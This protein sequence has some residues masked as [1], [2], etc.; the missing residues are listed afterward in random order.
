MNNKQS[1]IINKPVIIVIVIVLLISGFSILLNRPSKQFV[2]V[3][4]GSQLSTIITKSSGGYAYENTTNEFS[5]YFK[6]KVTDRNSISFIN[7]LGSISFYT[8]KNQKFG[9]LNSDSPPASAGSTITYP[10]IFNQ[11]DVR[12][13]ISTTTL[14]EEFIVKD[15][16][17][18]NQVTDIK[19]YA[20]TDL[21]YQKNSDG[22]IVFTK[23]GKIVFILPA[24]VL[25]EL[26]NKENRSTGIKYEIEKSGGQLNITKIITP[27]GLTWINDPKRQY[28]IVID[29]VIDNAD[30]ASSWVSSDATNTVVSQ[31]TTVKQEGTGSVKVQTTADVNTTVD[32]ME[33]SSDAAA[34]TAYVSSRTSNL[35]TGGS[36][37]YSGGNTIHT[38]T[39]S[40][41]FTPAYAMNVAVLVVGGGGGGGASGGGGGGGIQ[42]NAS[43]AISAGS[44]SVTVGGGGAVHTSGGSSVFSSLTALGGGYGGNS[45]AGEAGGNGAC[46]GGGGS[47]GG[48]AGSSSQG[49]GAGYGGYAA[50]GGGGG[51]GS[52]GDNFGGG[53]SENWGGAGG[54]GVAYSTS[55]SSIYYG[56]GGSGGGSAT[57]GSNPAKTGGTNAGVNGA[58]NTGAAGG[59]GGAGGSGIVIISYTTVSNILQSY[60][61]STIKT[62]GSYSLKGVAYATNSLNQTLT[63]TI[64]SPVNLSN[65]NS[66][67]F[68]I[69]STRTGANIKIGLHDSG[70]VTTEIT[71]NITSA[72]TFQSVNIDLSG[73][74]NVNKD[75]I[76][77]I[78]ITITNAG[79]DN[80]FYLDNF[81]KLTQPSLNDTVTLTKSATD[82]SAHTNIYFWVRST[83]AGQTFRF[84]FGEASSSEQTYNVTINTANTWEQ[85]TWNISG[86]SA[87]SRDAVTKF[88]FQITNSTSAQ[89]INFD[90]LNTNNIPPNVPIIDSP[91]NNQSVDLSQPVKLV[92]HA[93]DNDLDFLRYQIKICTDLAMTLNCNTYDQTSS[94]TGWSGQN[95]QSNTAYT[96]GSS[97][98][99][100]LQSALN[101][102]S[103]YFW[104]SKAIDSTPGSNTWGAFQSTASKFTTSA[105]PIMSQNCLLQKSPQNNSIT[106]NWS[107]I[108]TDENGYTIEKKI[109]SGA[110]SNL[111]NL[112]A[113]TVTYVDN[114][115]SSGH[116]YQY[117]VTSYYTGPI[118][119]DWC[120]TPALD[121]ET[122]DVHIEGV[123]M[124]G[125]QIY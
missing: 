79:A 1:T 43:Y 17:T 94:Q 93:T 124:E 64:G 33:Y 18:A 81:L 60:T 54:G 26:G 29:L 34:Q 23:K 101:P 99:Y 39:S 95:T 59:A 50:G 108:A 70:G 25:Y 71:P 97:A 45:A 117:R 68:D 82:L 3:Q 102:S 86:I 125:I 31:D 5:T 55:G 28:P 83:L 42:Y 98:T 105:P 88:A 107:D 51:M 63:R 76:D 115:V 48:G 72:N 11:M 8:P 89:T 77:Q 75:A 20:N 116:I 118:Y 90:L 106:I 38:F 9:Q 41:T 35:G 67:S 62:Q 30:T 7:S 73:V 57:G 91:S 53:D 58:T 46:G 13:T 14:L 66:A 6:E 4:D 111:I 84:Q 24:P 65:I 92:T 32:L 112:A 49:Y 12:Y 120:E 15:V 44:Y 40:G 96:S 47:W 110:Y 56:G 52:A 10:N 123:K 104:Q 37:T 61:E 78:I 119:G 22:S 114:S 16:F 122:G 113:N 103:N 21:E 27:E 19:Q 2:K 80:T 109:D 87:A 69:R 36:I 74:A 100:T 85:K 121:L